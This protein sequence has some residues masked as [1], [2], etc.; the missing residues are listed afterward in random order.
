MNVQ[1]VKNRQDTPKGG[2]EREEGGE[3]EKGE[4]AE[5]MMIWGTS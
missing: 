5:E 1:R 2:G 4:G 3:K